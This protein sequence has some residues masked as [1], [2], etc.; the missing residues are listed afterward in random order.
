MGRRCY[1]FSATTISRLISASNRAQKDRE[2]SELIRS[3]QGICTEQ[4]PD[5]SIIDF[6]FRWFYVDLSNT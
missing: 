1:G 5:Y 3:Q 4:E 6:Y 2:R